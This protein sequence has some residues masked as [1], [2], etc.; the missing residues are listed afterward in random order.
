MKAI[1]RTSLISQALSPL[2]DLLQA[3]AAR[4]LLAF[5]ALQSSSLTFTQP[6]STLF[7]SNRIQQHGP[8]RATTP[9]GP[10]VGVV[11]TLC[12]VETGCLSNALQGGWIKL[13][14]GGGGRGGWI[15]R[16]DR[17]A[18]MQLQGIC[19]KKAKE[20]EEGRREGV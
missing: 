16:G 6:T 18:A 11:D 9:P 2:P 4:D 3:S 7:Y 15:R 17:G 1:S 10:R 14:W 8:A 5:A 20:D 13:W 12:G 19:R